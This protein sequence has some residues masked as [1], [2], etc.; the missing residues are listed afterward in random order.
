MAEQLLYG[1]DVVAGFE[2]VGG[3]G[4]AQSFPRNFVFQEMGYNAPVNWKE[5][6]S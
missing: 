5:K 6:R 1:A 2:Q 3:K 4:M